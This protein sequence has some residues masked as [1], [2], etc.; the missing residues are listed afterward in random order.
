MVDVCHSIWNYVQANQGI[1]MQIFIQME[2]RFVGKKNQHATLSQI[3]FRHE[4]PQSSSHSGFHSVVAT[5]FRRQENRNERK[6][7]TKRK[8]LHWIYIHI[9][10][11]WHES[12]ALFHTNFDRRKVFGMD[13]VFEYI[14]IASMVGSV[15]TIYHKNNDF[16]NSLINFIACAILNVV[17][18]VKT[19]F[20]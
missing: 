6:E 3:Q 9:E 16:P 20:L 15:F 8:T 19:N 14:W 2:F 4:N 17:D 11:K 5:F 12:W 7:E 10:C 1:E 13:S 18:E